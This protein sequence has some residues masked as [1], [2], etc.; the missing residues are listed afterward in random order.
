MT[1]IS[2]AQNFEDVML[3]RAL[4]HVPGGTYIDVGAQDPIVDSVSKAFHQ[5]GWR[6]IH[7][8]PVPRYAEMLRQDRPDET[9]LQLALSDKAGTLDLH[10]FEDTGLS[11]GVQEIADSHRTLQ[12][13]AHS[14]VPTPMLPMRTAFESLAGQPVHWLKIDVEGLEEA[15]LRGWDSRALR[16][17]IIVIEATV[18]MSAEV[19]F[20]GAEDILLAAD[21]EFVYFDGLNRFYVAKEHPELKAAFATPPN[22]FDEVRLSGLA[23]SE[24]CRGLL[25]T[26]RAETDR[27]EEAHRVAMRALE[28]RIKALR[29]RVLEV[30]AATQRERRALEEQARRDGQTT[31]AALQSSEQQRSAVQHRLDAMLNSTSWRITAPIRK[32]GSTRRRLLS[33][34]REGRLTSG[35]KRRIKAVLRSCALAVVRHPTLKRGVLACLRAVPPLHLR[36]CQLLVPPPAAAHVGS[37]PLNE[38]LPT[39]SPAAHAIYLALK[40]ATG[41]E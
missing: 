1:F 20:Q 36:V 19:R 27:L 6:G 8:E 34:V 26:H 15:V 10:V 32:I 18:P 24:L 5:N 40:A 13:R 17:W 3:W 29:N 4:K 12:H 25:E 41:R 9:V 7:V 16:P 39:M 38:T 33:A 22:V 2:Y 30:E 35:I 11:T 28:Q 31:A 23:S 21:Y 37:P 14:I